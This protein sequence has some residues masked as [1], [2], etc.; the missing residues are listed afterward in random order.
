MA[1]ITPPHIE[2]ISDPPAGSREQTAPRPRAKGAAAGKSSLPHT[3]EISVPEDT[4][5]HKLD[6]MA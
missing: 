3:P 6:E 2:S 1:E 4:E 5:K